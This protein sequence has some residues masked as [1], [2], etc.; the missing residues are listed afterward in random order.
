MSSPSEIY[1][2]YA[3][4]V[5]AFRPVSA[6]ASSPA[7]AFL[8][9]ARSLLSR[10]PMPRC[11]R[12]SAAPLHLSFQLVIAEDKKA[13]GHHV[14]V[15]WAPV[16]ALCPS[17]PMGRVQGGKDMK[18]RPTIVGARRFPVPTV[19]PASSR[20]FLKFTVISPI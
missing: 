6:R 13:P 15:K 11:G 17:R 10:R 19:Y 4:L 14:Y 7:R 16:L 18:Q 1:V 20:S 12:L 9:L 3:D 2:T 8:T 5:S